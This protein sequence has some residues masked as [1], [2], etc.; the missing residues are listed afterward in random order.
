VGSGIGRRGA[1]LQC[2]VRVRDLSGEISFT[3]GKYRQGI[4]QERTRMK[5][6]E[7]V[8]FSIS[9]GGKK[10]GASRTAEGAKS[11]KKVGYL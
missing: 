11:E 2:P 6:F 5:I 7:Y 1:G 3:G 8:A 4:R 9:P 10:E